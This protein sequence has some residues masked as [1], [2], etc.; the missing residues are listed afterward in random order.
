MN[1]LWSVISGGLKRLT[2]CKQPGQ[3]QI[4]ALGLVGMSMSC[5]VI[6]V[7]I[8]LYFNQVRQAQTL[9]DAAALAGAAKLPQGNSQAQQAAL[10]MAQ[11]NPYGGE[12]IKASQ[13]TYTIN[14]D[15]MTVTTTGSYTPIFSKFLCNNCA[16]IPLKAS[17]KAQPAARDTV[18]VI[19]ASSSMADLGNN[20]PMND[21][22][23]AAKLFVDTLAAQDNQLVDRIAV[24]SFHQ[25]ASKK[26]GLTAK[27][28]FANV[29]TAISNISMFSGSGWNTNYEVGLRMALDELETN[30]RPNANQLVLFMTDGLPNLPAPASFYTYSSTAPYNKCID[31]VNNSAGVKALCVTKTVNGKKTTTCPTLPNAQITDNLISAAAVQ[32]GMDYTN[33]MVSSTATQ[34][35]RAKLKGVVITYIVIDDPST[36]DNA[37]SI[38][39]RLRKEPSWKP[40]L[41][42]TMASETGGK[43]YSALSYDATAISNLYKNYAENIH[44]KLSG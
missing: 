21:V 33:F 15:A 7:D 20:R 3:N 13:L 8:P 31:M 26:I 38:L 34:T 43:G 37:N 11:A 10:A 23:T 14:K 40:M 41:L 24:V 32:C 5:G 30:G 19:D 42:E 18:L 22:K 35:A 9:T 2:R 25:T 17:S 1:Q 12:Q 6:L 27:S 44:I 4:L 36:P 29:K 28:G 16:A 39:R